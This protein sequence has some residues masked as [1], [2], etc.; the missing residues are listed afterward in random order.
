VKTVVAYFMHDPPL[1]NYQIIAILTEEDQRLHKAHPRNEYEARQLKHAKEAVKAIK[2]LHA[3]NL[4]EAKGDQ[5]IL[6]QLDA[7][8]RWAEL[9]L[10]SNNRYLDTANPD[11]FCQKILASRGLP[12]QQV[13]IS[14][15]EALQ[16]LSGQNVT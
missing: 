7:E 15:E 11:A 3:K 5:E 12:P 1:S 4:A 8:I 14:V 10:T 13:Q 6:A 16:R 2:I 9:Q